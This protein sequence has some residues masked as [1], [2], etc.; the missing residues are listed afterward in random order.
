E[1]VAAMRRCQAAA[2]ELR[3][4]IADVPL[5]W[6]WF[7]RAVETDAPD[8]VALGAKALELHRRTSIVTMD[9]LSGIHAIRRAGVGEAVP[10]DVVASAAASR[11]PGFRA[12]VAHA[13]V[14][15]SDIAG[16]VGLLG[17]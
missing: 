5:A 1:A 2:T 4:S 15:A 16:A 8:R 10:P 14:E 11:N 12:L 13:M 9:E 3:H 7:M 17:S 6:W